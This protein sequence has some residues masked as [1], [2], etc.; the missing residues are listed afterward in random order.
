MKSPS[1][2]I[3]KRSDL[4]HLSCTLR[5]LSTQSLSKVGCFPTSTANSNL[6]TSSR[7]PRWNPYHAPPL[8]TW[9]W[10]HHHSATRSS[11]C[12][13]SS[14]H[15]YTCWFLFHRCWH[16]HYRY[17]IISRHLLS[18]PAEIDTQNFQLSGSVAP[19]HCKLFSLS[20]ALRLGDC[21]SGCIPYSRR[22]I[23]WY[24]ESRT[25]S[26]SP[27]VAALSY[28]SRSRSR[29]RLGWC[30][31]RWQDHKDRIIRFQRWWSIGKSPATSR[32]SRVDSR[33]STHISGWQSWYWT[34]AGKYSQTRR[35]PEFCIV[36]RKPGDTQIQWF[37][38]LHKRL[39]GM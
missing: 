13:Q 17:C 32:R 8:A 2:Q 27:Q 12:H 18:T 39:E 5:N 37:Q 6:Q 3:Q 35:I 28:R 1:Q 38:R 20:R 15:I 26:K 22:H 21:K 11:L 10:T 4:L 25:H 19:L 33:S 31:K 24:T 23:R 36:I 34:G 30:H 9:S 7:S 14:F 29:S 16:S